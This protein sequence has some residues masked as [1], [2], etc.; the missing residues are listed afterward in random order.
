M[1]VLHA[2]YGFGALVAPLSATQFA[3]ARHWSFHYII[4]CGLA[5]TAMVLLVVIFRGRTLPRECRHETEMGV[6]LMNDVECLDQIEL[7]PD[8]E[9]TAKLH[10]NHQ[11]GGNVFGKLMRLR[12]VHLLS[13]FVFVYVGVEVTLG[14]ESESFYVSIESVSHAENAKD[15][16]LL[17]SSPNAME[18]LHR[19]TSVLASSVVSL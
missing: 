18:A 4:S 15:G 19:D 9:E 13:F 1:G 16:W 12:A 5:V 7:A 6:E 14:G 2:I 11:A 8:E 17:M 10:E 3:N